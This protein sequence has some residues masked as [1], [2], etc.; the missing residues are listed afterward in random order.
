M[1]VDLSYPSGHSVND[2]ISEAFTSLSYVSV[3]TAA[4]AVLRMGKGTQLAKLDIRSAYRNIPVHPHDRWLLGMVWH[5]GVFID[6]VLPFGLRS[7]P[8]IFNAVADALEW[9]VR[10]NGVREIYHY[11]DD[12]LVI[13]TPGSDECTRSLDSLLTWT[14]W[15]GFPVAEEKVEGPSS[16]ITFLGIE[17]D[18]E[19]MILRL[20]EDKLRS[21]KAL[22]KSWRERHWCQR[23]SCSLWPASY[24]ML[25]R[26]CDLGEPF[27]VVC[28]NY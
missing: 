6:T 9:V 24:S 11:L 16:V 27:Y 23:L 7:A 17:I 14:E 3:E 12:F 28:S 2:G 18:S 1:I 4:Q 19:A 13:G 26:W 15:L 25:V 20:P 5:G 21:L 22:V 8:K 10:H